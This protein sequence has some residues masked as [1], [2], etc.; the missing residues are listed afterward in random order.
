MAKR[1]Y[2]KKSAYWDN[3]KPAGNVPVSDINKAGNTDQ[4]TSRLKLGELGTTALNTMNV[5]SKFM[6][7]WDCAWPNSL[8][9]YDEMSKDADV[10]T[11]LRANYLFVER[12]F[13]NFTVKGKTGN[14]KSEDAA[15]MVDWALRNMDG[16]TLKQA[17][18][19]ILSYKVFGFSIVEKAYTKV[20]EGEYAGKYKIKK[21]A[22]RPQQTLRT[23]N[24]FKFSAD[25]RDVLAVYQVITNKYFTSL[26]VTNPL[27]GEIEIP[28]NKFMLFGEQITDTNPMGIS[29][30]STI[31]IPWK[32]K[33][34]IS[35]YEIIGVGKDLA[36]MPVLKVPVDILNR[37]AEDPNSEE[38]RSINTLRSNLASM[39]AGEEAYM[40][41][42]SDPHENTSGMPQYAIQFLGVDGNG[43]S[44]DTLALKQERKKDIYD[45]F[46]AAHLIIG[47]GDQAGSFALSDNKQNLHSQFIE[48]DVMGI[49]EVINKDL[50]PQ[51]LALNGIYLTDEEMPVF[52]PGDVGD[53]DIEGNSKMIQRVV[54]VGAIPLTPE[55]MNEFMTMC[56]LKYQIPDEI[57]SDEVKLKEFMDQY[58][59]ESVS[60]SGDGIAAGGLNGTS[61][62]TSTTNT[63]TS[64]SENAA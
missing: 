19:E 20:T 32:E 24:P 14:K 9:V 7:D 3:I 37:A 63:S 2:N 48:H 27:I 53:P 39:H 49:S 13:D 38:A 15:K 11:A 56:G 26:D 34:L 57:L 23:K 64:N 17:V 43:K 50:L 45:S 8:Y 18:R 51:F 40:I 10:A 33:C 61:S 35:E 5:Y 60:R 42:P 1:Q 36:G 30:L 47:G 29:P 22:P 12:A 41:I 4:A 52:S 6:K 28:R 25:G 44:F 59:P 62:S 46:G 54:A 16:Q 58:L 31:Y 55:V 21:L